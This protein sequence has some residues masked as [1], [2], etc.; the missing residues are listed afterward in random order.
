MS[1]AVRK[2]NINFLTSKSD[3]LPLT[4]TFRSRKFKK[5][6]HQLKKFFIVKQI[7]LTATLTNVKVK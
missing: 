4:Q 2:F 3:L 5:N 7:F 6:Y 1:E